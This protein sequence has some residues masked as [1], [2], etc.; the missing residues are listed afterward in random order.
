MIIIGDYSKAFE[1]CWAHYAQ[2]LKQLRK[3][4][5]DYGVRV[6][7]V[8]LP[9][10]A[11]SK[12]MAWDKWQFCLK[13]IRF[14]EGAVDEELL[15]LAVECFCSQRLEECHKLKK[16]R[17]S[18]MAVFLNPTPKNDR[19]PEILD[20]IIL[21]KDSKEMEKQ[22]AEAPNTRGRSPIIGH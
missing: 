18:M 14:K 13:Q 19:Q 8:Y 9:S 4:A 2:T 22:N 10:S 15:M 12:Q 17:M 7:E 21:A 20:F 16:V 6:D 1:V 11:G 5:M 3:F